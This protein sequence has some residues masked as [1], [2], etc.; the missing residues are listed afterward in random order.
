MNVTD[1]GHLTGDADDG[2]DKMEKSARETGRSPAEIAE[3]Y[4]AAF[5]EDIDRL[6]IIR[7]KT[8]CT[9]TKH[10]GNMIALIKRLEEKGYTYIEGGN[11]YFDTEKFENYGELA[12]LDR[13][14]LKAG[15]RIAVD[16][17]K[18]N[19]ADFVLWFT[20]SKFENHIMQWNSPWGEGYPGWHIEMFC[21]EHEISG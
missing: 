1:V 5:F 6:N 13:Q 15:A 11:V 17:N 20:N 12:L 18:K 19:P 16:G 7:P 10:I 8:A 21:N 3:Y 2:E 9:A 14:N 4:T